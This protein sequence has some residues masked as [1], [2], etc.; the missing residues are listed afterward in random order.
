[1]TST[2]YIQAVIRTEATLHAKGMQRIDHATIGICSEAGELADAYKRAQFYDQIYDRINAKEELGD[3][4]WYMSIIMDVLD[5]TWEEIWEAN[6]AKLKK[7]Y[8]EQFTKEAAAEE[9]RDREAER[10][11]LDPWRD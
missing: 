4:C 8:P 10:E 9:N 5:C 3:L 2:E 6:I 7:R 11:A 1:M